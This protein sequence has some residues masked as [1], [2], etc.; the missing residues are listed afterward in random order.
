[1]REVIFDGFDGPRVLRN[2]EMPEPGVQPGSPA[3]RRPCRLCQLHGLLD[4][5]R[6]KMEWQ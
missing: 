3:D 4:G 2:G 5:V 1:M 6:L